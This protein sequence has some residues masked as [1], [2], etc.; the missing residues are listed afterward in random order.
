VM[1]P[2]GIPSR[3]ARLNKVFAASRCRD[4][5]Q[6]LIG[7]DWAP[8]R[9]CEELSP[10]NTGSETKAGGSADDQLSG[11]VSGGGAQ[12][13]YPAQPTGNSV[14]TGVFLVHQPQQYPSEDVAK[15]ARPGHWSITRYSCSM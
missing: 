7:A 5:P 11:I 4:V 6:P 1:P 3:E 10:G 14:P 13:L 9:S 8:Q 15:A 12:C 2:G